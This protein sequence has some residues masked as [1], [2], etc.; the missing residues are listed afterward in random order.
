VVVVLFQKDLEVFG[1]FWTKLFVQSTWA[2]I[3]ASILN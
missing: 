1:G 2:N 3:I